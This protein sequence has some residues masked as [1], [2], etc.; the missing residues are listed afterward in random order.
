M[1]YKML[2]ATFFVVIIACV[3]ANA[4][5]KLTVLDAAGNPTATIKRTVGFGSKFPEKKA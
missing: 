3:I 2:L 5:T 4:M 1:N